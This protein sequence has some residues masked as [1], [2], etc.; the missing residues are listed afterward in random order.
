MTLCGYSEEDGFVL[1][2]MSVDVPLAPGPEEEEE[3]QQL[4][5]RRPA[6][7]G[8]R[9]PRVRTPRAPFLAVACHLSLIAGARAWPG[10]DGGNE[11]RGVCW[12][13]GFVGWMDWPVNLPLAPRRREGRLGGASLRRAIGGNISL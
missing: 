5:G 11:S 1:L 13:L 2:H 9:T 6:A 7:A 8:W 4:A 12:E 3:G 10:V